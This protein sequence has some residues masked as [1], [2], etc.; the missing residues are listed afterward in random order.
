MVTLCVARRTFRLVAMRRNFG[1]APHQTDVAPNIDRFAP[2][3]EHVEDWI[4]K[5]E[6]IRRHSGALYLGSP[7]DRFVLDDLSST[8]RSRLSF[9]VQDRQSQ[10]VRNMVL[11]L[12]L[13]QR[14]SV[15]LRTRRLLY[16]RPREHVLAPMLLEEEGR[17]RAMTRNELTS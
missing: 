9:A 7:V 10:G 5:R 8:S 1:S 15:G 11:L 14:I 12:M 17:I 2:G 13:G 6:R 16:R 3:A 4:A